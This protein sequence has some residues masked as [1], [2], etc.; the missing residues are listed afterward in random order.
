VVKP[1]RK[2]PIVQFLQQAYGVSCRK[3]CR[4]IAF[5]RSVRQW[6]VLREDGQFGTLMRQGWQTQVALGAEYGFDWHNLTVGGEWYYDGSGQTD[7]SD[8]DWEA[9]L[10]GHRVTLAQHYAAV[11]GSLL[12]T[13]LW[14]FSIGAILNLDDHSFII[15]PQ[16]VYSVTQQFDVRA[17]IQISG[18]E[19]FSEYGGF[20][21]LYYLI[22]SRYF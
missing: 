2:R 4:A 1:G 21:N 6:V 3:A 8:Y 12:I 7:R 19:M 18:G 13:P 17:G 22:F 16:M 5:N 15:L 10:L 14:T 9:L 20:P 11:N